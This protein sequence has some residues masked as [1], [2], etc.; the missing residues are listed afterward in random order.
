MRYIPP[1]SLVLATEPKAYVGGLVDYREGRVGDWCT[2]FADATRRASLMAVDL[3]R[4]ID[5]L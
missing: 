3:S 5:S 2:V 4:D 1:I